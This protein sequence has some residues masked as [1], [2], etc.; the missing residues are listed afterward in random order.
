MEGLKICLLNNDSHFANTHLLQTNG[1]ATGA[2]NL[3]SFF[4]VAFCHLKV[5]LSALFILKIFKFL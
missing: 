1:T 3:C 2:P 5:G 4:D